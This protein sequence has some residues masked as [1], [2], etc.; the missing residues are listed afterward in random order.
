MPLAQLF[1]KLIAA[2]HIA[3]PQAFRPNHRQPG[4]QPCSSQSEHTPYGMQAFVEFK[5][6]AFAIDHMQL[7]NH[8]RSFQTSSMIGQYTKQ[9]NQG[10]PL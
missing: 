8:P 6:Y 3:V 7:I 1:F 4:W 2:S 5:T 9:G 10:P